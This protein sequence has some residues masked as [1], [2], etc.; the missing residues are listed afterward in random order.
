LGYCARISVVNPDWKTRWPNLVE[1]HF[2]VTSKDTPDYNCVAFAAGEV[3]QWWEPYI[4]PPP[5]GVYWPDG[6]TP[7]NTLEAW[8][9][10]YAT[11][12]FE[13][14][15]DASLEAEFVK[16]AIYADVHGTPQHVARQLKD[17]RWA[18]RL[19]DLEDIEHCSLEAL[20]NGMYGSAR[21]FLKRPRRAED[22]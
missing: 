18:S 5:P 3:D 9:E 8:A 12:E 10:A 11:R 1:P 13:R 7:D 16:I 19:G 20:E 22:P 6:V 14:C 4:F 21:M 2:K 15:V 17:G